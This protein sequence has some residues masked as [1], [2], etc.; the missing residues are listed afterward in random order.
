[1]ARPRRWQGIRLFPFHGTKRTCSL[2]G[3]GA[4]AHKPL[5]KTRG[6]VWGSAPQ[7]LG[8]NKS[9]GVRIAEMGAAIVLSI[10]VY[11]LGRER[12][13]NVFHSL[14]IAVQSVAEVVPRL[15]SA[16]DFRGASR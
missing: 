15:K 16:P 5:V 12:N 4:A 1:M 14:C 9:R 6:G 3:G 7:T 8:E 13:P 10:P 2:A 11:V